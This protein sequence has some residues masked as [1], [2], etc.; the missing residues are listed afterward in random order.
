MDLDSSEVK[1]FEAVLAWKRAHPNLAATPDASA[2]PLFDYGT[3]DS[4]QQSQTHVDKAKRQEIVAQ[5]RAGL[6]VNEIAATFGI[7][8]KTVREIAKSAGLEPKP[9]GLCADQ[10]EEAAGLYSSG[11]SLAAVGR[12]LGFEASTV[13]HALKRH[14]VQ[15]RPRQGGRRPASDNHTHHIADYPNG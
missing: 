10:V 11:L 6:G 13:M 3:V 2:D 4:I 15:M 9:R 5:Y 1:L 7:H 14:G 8:R 12:R